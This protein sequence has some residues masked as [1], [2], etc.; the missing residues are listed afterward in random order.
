MREPLSVYLC[1][2]TQCRYAHKCYSYGNS[3]NIAQLLTSFNFW[4]VLIL[5]GTQNPQTTT[6]K[7]ST[8]I[9]NLFY[10]REKAHTITP[11]LLAC[12]PCADDSSVVVIAD[13]S[14]EEAGNQVGPRWS[15][16]PPPGI[17]PASWKLIQQMQGREKQSLQR[18][19][20]WL[21]SK[22]CL[23]PQPQKRS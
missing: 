18:R 19:R 9:I 17:D 15:V 10:G 12:L 14:D 16:Q 23:S 22:C 1:R 20:C 7:K 3:D 4:R 2:S 8:M 11:E 5:E 13:S 6:K 21:R